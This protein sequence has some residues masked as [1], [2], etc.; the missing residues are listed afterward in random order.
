MTLCEKILASSSAQSDI[1]EPQLTRVMSVN[2]TDHSIGGA[3]QRK[4]KSSGLEQINLDHILTLNSYQRHSKLS[5]AWVQLM[6]PL[7]TVKAEAAKFSHRSGA[8]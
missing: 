8:K 5:T 3:W 4:L 6:Y 7:L 1:P 2:S